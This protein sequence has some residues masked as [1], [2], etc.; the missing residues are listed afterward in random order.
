MC[1]ELPLVA[2]SQG[3][4]MAY[5]SVQNAWFAEPDGPSFAASVRAGFDDPATRA[6]RAA[7]GRRTALEH[8]WDKIAGRFF[9]TY[10]S[11]YRSYPIASDRHVVRLATSCPLRAAL[12][13]SRR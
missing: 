9:D 1:S 8:D 5:C 6:A 13:R 11:F 2:P 10:D 3:G 12:V 4:V 7:A